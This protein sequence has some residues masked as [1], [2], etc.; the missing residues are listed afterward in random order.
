MAS[1]STLAGVDVPALRASLLAWY[2]HNRRKL[3]WRGDDPPPDADGGGG[4]GAVSAYGTWVS[5]VMLQQTRVATV[6]PYWRKWMARFP[7]VAAL[8]AADEEAVRAAWAG[9][10]FYRRAAHLWAGAKHVVS[11]CGGSVPRDVAGLLAV[12]G[13]GPY[14]AGAVASIAHGVVTPAVDGNVI[15]VVCR[16]LAWEMDP[17][18]SATLKQVRSA[19]AVAGAGRCG[20]PSAPF[21][22]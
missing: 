20:H 8:A 13:I 5:E 1:S 14:T 22:R 6:V 2:A 3:P 4:S 21:H 16:L 12:P 19:L 11:K 17:K 18:A 9:L 7:D 15:R 10:G